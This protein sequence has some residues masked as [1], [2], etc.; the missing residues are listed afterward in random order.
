MHMAAD[1]RLELNAEHRPLPVLCSRYEL[2]ISVVARRLLIVLGVPIPLVFDL[3]Q[4]A[5]IALHQA[6]D[7]FFYLF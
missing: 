1:P 6:R 5:I 7:L 2:L 3:E 4:L